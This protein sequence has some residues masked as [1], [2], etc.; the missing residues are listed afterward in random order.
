MQALAMLPA[1]KRIFAVSRAA[2]APYWHVPGKLVIT[3]NGL[4]PDQVVPERIGGTLRARHGLAPD[5]PLVGM[6]GRVIH[7]KGVDLFLHAAGRI[8]GRFPAARFV[9][10]G[11]REGDAFDRELDAIAVAE[12]IA[13]R[14]IF[15]GWVDDMLTEL[16]DLDV[17]AI[18][19]RRDAAPLVCFEAMALGR[20]VV[21]TRCP[22]LDEQFQ[23]EV[24]GLYVPRRDV[25]ALAAGMARLVGD[26]E[27]RRRFGRE[28]R[29]ALETRFDLRRMVRR[30]E[31]S[32][33]R[34][35]QNPD[36]VLD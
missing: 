4:D 12:G 28:A 29:R 1:V 9:V 25:D 24:S 13:D 18:P 19:S 26:A 35:A 36:A 33:V 6:A 21:A 14:V 32:L 3:Y 16:C 20:A 30:V 23:D 27:L 8:A 22:G 34:L 17:V 7:L 31:D 15:T 2:A 11:R 5:V 10:I